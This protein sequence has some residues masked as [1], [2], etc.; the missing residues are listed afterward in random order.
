MPTACLP[1]GWLL[2]S[3][4][5]VCG[6]LL[7]AAV[8]LRLSGHHFAWERP[9]ADIPALWLSGGL[10]VAGLVYVL[11][12]PLIHRTERHDSAWVR[13]LLGL[14]LV[15][16]LAMRLTMLS[17]VPALEDDFYRYLWDGAV[18]AHG[19]N[20][21]AL[22]PQSARTDAAPDAIRSLAETGALVL[23]RV[24]HPALKTIYPP[25]AEAAFALA[26]WIEPWSLR[27]WRL[28]CLLGECASLALLLAILGLVGRS[29]LWVSLYW[30]NPLVVKELANS[31]HMEAIVMPFVLSAVLLL[32]RNRPLAASASLGLAIGA[33]LWPVVL[34]SPTD[35][36]PDRSKARAPAAAVRPCSSGAIPLR[37]SI[38]RSSH[39]T[40]DSA[41]PAEGMAP[42]SRCV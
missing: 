26:Y 25:V 23:D 36:V 8:I 29:P 39:G 35:V 34:T 18:L 6:L 10:I 7:S 22:A 38:M 28:V 11:L 33:K 17:A 42:I 9:L 14:I 12:L 4:L 2:W 40:K 24:N 20:P 1:S 31:A 5:S 21:Y 13:P 16:G 41:G 37:V 30:L 15:T 3:W 32:A 19:H 27:A